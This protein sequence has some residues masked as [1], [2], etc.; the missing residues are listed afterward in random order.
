[1][2]LSVREGKA[3]L[4]A[5]TDPEDISTFLIRAVTVVHP[6]SEKRLIRSA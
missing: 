4:A 2:T 1:V 6:S 5:S 3:K